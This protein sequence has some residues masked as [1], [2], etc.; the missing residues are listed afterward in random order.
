MAVGHEAHSMGKNEL[1]WTPDVYMGHKTEKPILSHPKMQRRSSQLWVTTLIVS[2]LLVILTRPAPVIELSRLTFD[3][4]LSQTR[5]NGIV[6]NLPLDTRAPED[7]VEQPW[8]DQVTFDNYSL[9]LKGQRIF[10]QYAILIAI[11]SH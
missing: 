3:K 1:Q 11:K 5:F 4:I 8:T 10:I 2:I 9:F 6:P 7:A